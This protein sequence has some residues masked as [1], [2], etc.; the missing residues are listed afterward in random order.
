MLDDVP[1]VL[2]LGA[3]TLS[4]LGDHARCSLLSVLACEF[5]MLVD[6]TCSVE[7]ILHL[8]DLLLEGVRWSSSDT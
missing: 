7:Y 6:A 1:V 3:K 5:S 2:A 4:K 8:T